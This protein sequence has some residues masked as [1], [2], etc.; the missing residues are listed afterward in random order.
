MQDSKPV[1]YTRT[2]KIIHW[3][4]AVL[5]I[6]QIFMGWELDNQEGAE[7]SESLAY[8]VQGGLL[9]LGLLLLRLF[10]RIGN[11]TPALPDSISKA[12]KTVS[13]I[14]HKLMYVTMLAAPLSGVTALAAHESPLYL[15]NFNIKELLYF[16]GDDNFDLR[17]W[18]HSNVINLLSLLIIAHITA[19]FVHLIVKKDGVFGRMLPVGKS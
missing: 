5:V 8:H 10:W 1:H 7:L 14:T 2:A 3:L 15:S 6:L 12:Q 16:L 19:A 11:P 9:I 4:M 13:K 18:F 17:Y